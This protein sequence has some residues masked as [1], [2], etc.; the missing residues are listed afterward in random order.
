MSEWG[1]KLLTE[2]DNARLRAENDR[3]R[4]R[5]HELEI[6]YDGAT[7]AVLEKT[8]R[9]EWIAGRLRGETNENADLRQA[10]ADLWP[11]ASFTMC[12]EN[13]ESW[14]ERLAELGVE[15]DE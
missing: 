11:R 8:E 6:E 12:P 4:E 14:L 15:V 3:L 2:A 9:I 10:L 7:T 13:R 5:V 1:D